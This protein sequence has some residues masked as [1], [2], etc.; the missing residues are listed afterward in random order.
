MNNQEQYNCVILNVSSLNEFFTQLENSLSY[1]SVFKKL[2]S[3]YKIERNFPDMS[4]FRLGPNMFENIPLFIIILVKNNSINTED[5]QLIAHGVMTNICWNKQS[6]DLPEGWQGAV[7][8]SYENM[9]NKIKKNALVGLYIR[10]EEQ[11][12][13]HGYAEK[14]INTMKN[15]ASEQRYDSLIIPLRLPQR[16]TLSYAKMKYLKFINLKRK[17]GQY[18]DHWLRIHTRLG[19]NIIGT[20]LTSHQHAMNLGDFLTQFNTKK[21]RFSGYY[22][23]ERQGLWYNV[24]VDTKRKIALINQECTWVNH[25]PL[26][27]DN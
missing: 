10:V 24:Y 11:F 3:L 18:V 19:G 26:G 27:L 5:S 14:I 9:Q 17:D 23:S 15:F 7:R 12:K 22:L 8:R 6:T 4:H 20:C 2:L 25:A 16:Y 21:I 1:R 13:Q